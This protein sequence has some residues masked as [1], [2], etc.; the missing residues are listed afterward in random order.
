MDHTESPRAKPVGTLVHLLECVSSLKERCCY[1]AS[2]NYHISHE[3]GWLSLNQLN[4]G[5]HGQMGS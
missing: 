4:L 3:A 2:L 5:E 1:K